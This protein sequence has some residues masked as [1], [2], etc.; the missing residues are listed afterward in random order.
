MGKYYCYLCRGHIFCDTWHKISNK[1]KKIWDSQFKS[2]NI[3]L[4]VGGM[5]CGKHGDF[6][7][8]M[9]Y[10]EVLDGDY[11]NQPSSSPRG[12]RKRRRVENKHLAPLMGDLNVKLVQDV[13]KE[14]CA[15]FGIKS[16]AQLLEG[17]RDGKITLNKPHRQLRK[18]FCELSRTGIM[19]F[20]VDSVCFFFFLESESRVSI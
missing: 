16:I 20:I 14:H 15:P 17:L 9:D 12:Q 5:I 19:F 18:P 8:S 13:L 10:F 11:W 2:L 1:R 7:K 6:L 4:P 3:H